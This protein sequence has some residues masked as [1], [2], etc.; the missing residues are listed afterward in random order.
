MT[1]CQEVLCRYLHDVLSTEALSAVLRQLL[2]L[3][4]PAAYFTAG[5]GHGPEEMGAL[6]LL[7]THVPASEPLLTRVCVMALCD[8]DPSTQVQA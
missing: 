4:G 3:E 2:F 1:W 6:Q 5:E 8:K 7:Q